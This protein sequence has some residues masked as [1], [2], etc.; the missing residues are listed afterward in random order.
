MADEEIIKMNTDI[1]LTDA[2]GNPISVTTPPPE[3]I[4][5]TFNFKS[6]KYSGRSFE[7]NGGGI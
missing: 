4:T 2:N 7:P 3:Y 5:E 6:Q 1:K